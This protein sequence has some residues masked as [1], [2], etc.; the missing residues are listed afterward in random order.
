MYSDEEKIQ[1]M[2]DFEKMNYYESQNFAYDDEFAI[3]LV[4]IVKRINLGTLSLDSDEVK[5]AVLDLEFNLYGQG[6]FLRRESKFF[7][8]GFEIYLNVGLK[9]IQI[10]KLNEWLKDFDYQI[11]AQ[12]ENGFASIN[13]LFTLKT[14]FDSL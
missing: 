2:K 8:E 3:T 5:Q 14:D 4:D 10:E 13:M 6:I 7:D 11:Y 12:Y 1:L 9:S